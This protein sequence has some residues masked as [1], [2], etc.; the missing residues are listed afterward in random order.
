MYVRGPE[1]N[2]TAEFEIRQLAGVAPADQGPVAYFQH[3]AHVPAVQHLFTVEA[4][5]RFQCRFE[6][7]NQ[8]SLLLKVLF[9]HRFELFDVIAVLFHT[10]IP[11]FE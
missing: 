3:Q 10:D 7:G 2:L 4:C 6:L 11:L 9:D 8:L 1:V 5:D